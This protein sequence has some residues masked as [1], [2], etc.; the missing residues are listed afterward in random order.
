MSL[1]STED[2]PML[3]STDK[4]QIP[5]ESCSSGLF[6]GMPSTAVRG[7]QQTND[8]DVNTARTLTQ[9]ELH[10][11]P[12]QFPI[13]SNVLTQTSV[14]QSSA[15]CTSTSINYSIANTEQVVYSSACLSTPIAGTIPVQRRT[16]PIHYG[17]PT[18]A[19]SATNWGNGHFFNSTDAH[20]PCSAVRPSSPLTIQQ[21]FPSQDLPTLMGQ[22]RR[23]KAITPETFDGTQDWEEYIKHFEDVAMWNEWNSEEKAAQLGLQLKGMAR[24]LKTDLPS[25]VTR[26]YDAL[27]SMLAKYFSCEGKEAAYQAEF[28]GRKREQNE[29]L[30][31]FGHELNR[32]CKKAFPKMERMSREQFVLEH[33]KQA[34]D[35][36]L[37]KHVQ[38]Q[39]PTTL[40]EAIVA[41]IEFEAMDEGRHKTRKP[42]Q[43]NVVQCGSGD[44]SSVQTPV[45]DTS[46]QQILKLME[47]N[48]QAS[49]RMF[50]SVQAMLDKIRRPTR[51]RDYSH[52]VC[53][54]CNEK[55]H[56]QYSCPNNEAVCS[57]GD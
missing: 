42:V 3:T 18:T 35:T 12:T 45:T 39:H 10:K 43:V 9:T 4:R 56:I 2:G 57:S 34:L 48:M 32:L 50:E 52:V 30:V 17:Q 27:V 23:R 37:R 25:S 15:S 11:P 55:G 22:T 8:V 38:F 14:S 47:Q 26:N 33:F 29:R 7:P 54:A 24:S 13:V 49:Q 40:E 51:R 28:R 1:T 19:N 21:H 41:A 6:S 20:N 16:V 44:S 46:V 36:D 5:G 53:F 31:D